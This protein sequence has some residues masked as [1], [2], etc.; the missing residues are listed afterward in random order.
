MLMILILE[1]C[2]II[3]RYQMRRCIMPRLSGS[4]AMSGPGVG[5]CTP[6]FPTTAPLPSSNLGLALE[7]LGQLDSWTPRALARVSSWQLAAGSEVNPPTANDPCAAW[8]VYP[9]DR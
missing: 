5:G 8:S 7:A 4:Q 6:P 9:S 1:G 2:Q 3:S